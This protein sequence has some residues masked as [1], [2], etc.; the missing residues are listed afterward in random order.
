MDF[1]LSEIQVDDYY[2]YE[3]VHMLCK[4]CQIIDCDLDRMRVGYVCS[5]CGEVTDG[6]MLAFPINIQILIE[7]IQ[8][9]FHIKSPKAEVIGSNY[10]NISTVL[11]FCVLKEALIN[12]LLKRAMEKT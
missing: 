5:T 8:T 10:S 1:K 7:Q 12:L 2:A 6:A 4:C 3:S 9:A 11:F